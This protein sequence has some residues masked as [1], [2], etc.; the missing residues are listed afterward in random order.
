MA[1]QPGCKAHN[2]CSVRGTVPVSTQLCGVD[3]AMTA[4]LL[5]HAAHCCADLQQAAEGLGVVGAVVVLDNQLQHF[6]DLCRKK[7]RRSQCMKLAH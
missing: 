7:E 4:G 2:T 3:A 6:C 5:Q 1:Q